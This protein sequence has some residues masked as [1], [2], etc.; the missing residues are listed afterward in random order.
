M[1]CSDG[2]MGRDD[3]ARVADEQGKRQAAI[4]KKLKWKLDNVTRMLCAIC[5]VIEGH[6]PDS[7]IQQSA[8]SVDGLREWWARHQKQDAKR[9]AKEALAKAEK[10]IKAQTKRNLEDLRTAAISK[11]TKAERDALGL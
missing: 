4:Q 9:K 11:L 7:P 1:P 10:D 2:G 5:E 8:G 6:H 3:Y